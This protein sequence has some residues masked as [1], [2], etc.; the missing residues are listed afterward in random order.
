MSKITFEKFISLGSFCSPAE[1]IMELGLRK[2]AYPFDWLISGDIALVNELIENKFT[3]FLDI[4]Q[5]LV[6]ENQLQGK[7]LK[8][9][10]TKYNIKFFHDFLKDEDLASQ[11]VGIKTK[12]DRRINRFYEALFSGNILFIRYINKCDFD[13]T[14]E[15]DRFIDI[16]KRYNNNF[17]IIV[18]KDSESPLGRLENA[19]FIL[20]VFEVEKDEGDV[21]RRKL[22]GELV[23][24]LNQHIDFVFSD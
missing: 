16:V 11:I 13:K 3:D 24:Y 2:C 7:Y 9:Q 19:D 10:N 22:P 6:M 8:I 18:V 12:Y 20:K 14:S 5:L 21:V 23:D 15:I 17:K 1:W 4:K